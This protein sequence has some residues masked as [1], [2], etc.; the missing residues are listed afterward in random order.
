MIIISEFSELH[1][2]HHGFLGRQLMMEVI[3]QKYDQKLMMGVIESEN[4]LNIW[5]YSNIDTIFNTSVYIFFNT[6]IFWLLFVWMWEASQN[7]LQIVM[8]REIEKLKYCSRANLTYHW[9][10]S[11]ESWSWEPALQYWMIMHLINL[12]KERFHFFI[13]N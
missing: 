8:I 11:P 4:Y 12:H 13:S 10:L 1:V 3:W 6:N 5:I 2:F 9:N 7:H